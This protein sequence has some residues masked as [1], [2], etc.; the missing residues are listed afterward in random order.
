MYKLLIVD[1]DEII[2]QGLGSCI[3]WE[4]HGISLIGL[5]YDGER[6]FRYVEEEGPD[7]VLAD[8]NMPFLD[9]MEFADLVRQ[10]YPEIKIIMLTAY[11]EFSY[12]QRAV[13]LQIFSYLTKPFTNQ[14]VLEA[15]C[16]AAEAV[17]ED[18]RQKKAIDNSLQFIRKKNLEEIAEYWRKEEEIELSAVKKGLQRAVEQRDVAAIQDLVGKTLCQ[19]QKTKKK[20]STADVFCVVELLRFSWEMTEDTQAYAS[21]RKDCDNIL[22]ALVRASDPA[23]LAEQALAYFSELGRYLEA[24]NTSSMEKRVNQAVEYICENYANPE[25][26]LEDVAREVCLSASYLGNCMKKYKKTS[27]VNLLNRVRIENAKKFLARTDIRSCEVAF[28]VG[29]NSSQYFSSSFKKST[30]MTP[31]A[32]REQVLQNK[33][34]KEV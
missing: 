33:Y 6:A 8:I 7:I 3:P 20:P 18:R 13:Q 27:Y 2:C 25:L 14:E 17:E 9:G 15:V 28:L 5:A 24:H 30:G 21:F 10:R 1:D 12:A 22:A 32:F 16:K 19:M 31:S 34:K 29:F 11:R 26:S 4:D 23:A